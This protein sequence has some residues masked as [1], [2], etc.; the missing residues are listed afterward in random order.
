[1][2][3]RRFLPYQWQKQAKM[4]VLSCVMLSAARNI[5]RDSSPS[6]QNDEKKSAFLEH[7][8]F[9]KIFHIILFFFHL[10]NLK[11]GIFHFG[12]E[13]DRDNMFRLLM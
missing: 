4:Q 7:S 3:K 13:L 8:F 11:V 2:P 1:M 9:V 6:A 5:S 12:C 10:H